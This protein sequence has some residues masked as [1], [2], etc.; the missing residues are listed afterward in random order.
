[1]ESE[2]L[3][4]IVEAWKQSDEAADFVSGSFMGKPIADLTVPELLYA[5]SA[6]MMERDM[7]K[8]E[9]YFRS[10]RRGEE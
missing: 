7:W 4:Q 10:S 2:R 6:M 8:G 9:L 5:L 3:K 1:M